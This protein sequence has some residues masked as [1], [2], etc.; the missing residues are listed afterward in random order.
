MNL[1]SNVVKKPGE[2]VAVSNAASC[3]LDAS[4]LIVYLHGEP[5]VE[6]VA[7]ALEQSACMS[8]VN[9][10]EVLSWFVERGQDP[11]EVGQTLRKRGLLG[12]LLEILP[13]TDQDSLIV[14]QLR[15][16]TKTYGLSLGDRAC[17]SLGLRLNLPVFTADRSWAAISVGLA[18][19]MV[20]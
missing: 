6:K 18:V 8:A 11:R 4:A 12:G 14:A 2:K 3:V 17:L 15:P 10:A 13:M 19:Q 5:G 1:L 7:D 16:L 20:R 9:W